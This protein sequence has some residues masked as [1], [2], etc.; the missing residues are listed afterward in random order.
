MEE[1]NLPRSDLYKWAWDAHAN[2][3]NG[4]YIEVITSPSNP[5]GIVRDTVVKKRRRQL[6]E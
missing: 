4:Q 6:W 3:E 5:D 1:I 2:K